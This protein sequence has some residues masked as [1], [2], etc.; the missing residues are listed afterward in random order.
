MPGDPPPDRF[1]A[2]QVAEALQKKTQ[3]ALSGSDLM[4]FSPKTDTAIH[5]LLTF[6]ASGR[7]KSVATKKL[8]CTARHT[9]LNS[10]E[11]VMR[12]L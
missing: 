1:E 9:Y 12:L 3:R 8:S 10:E 7:L 4:E 5:R 6:L 2:R 11:G